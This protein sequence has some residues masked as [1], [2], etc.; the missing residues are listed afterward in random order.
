MKIIFLGAPGAGKGTQA[1]NTAKL[2]NIPAISTGVIIRESIKNGSEAGLRAREFTDK[3]QLVPDET[4]IDIIKERLK[5]P[6]CANGF[7]LDGFPRTLPQAEALDKLGVEIDFAVSIEVS[8]EAIVERMSGRRVCASCG[9]SYH[10][11]YNP[12]KKENVCDK[13]GHDL[14]IRADDKPEVVCDRLKVYHEMTEPVKH[15]YAERGRLE[16]VEGQIEVK[17]T[18]ALTLKAIEAGIE[19]AKTRNDNA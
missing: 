19:K 2:Y 9:A 8:D 12:P 6:D 11:V 16:I 18:T 13:C 15:Y 5:M 14:G 4:V 3:G 7:I 10:V 1:E 17:D